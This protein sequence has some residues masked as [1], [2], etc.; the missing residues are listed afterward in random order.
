MTPTATLLALIVRVAVSGVVL[1]EGR[2]THHLDKLQCGEV[3]ARLRTTC[4]EQIQAGWECVEQSLQLINR[5]GITKDITL[6]SRL[7]PSWAVPGRTALDGY[8]AEWTC[9]QSQ[10]GRHYLDLLYTCGESGNGCASANP[11]GEWE[12]LVDETGRVVAGGRN[13]S[14]PG[15]LERLGLW[16]LLHGT[17]HVTGVGPNK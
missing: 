4:V 10:S 5:A 1:A 6:D 3:T 11:G 17:T 9:V 12:Q 2:L 16:K 15:S 8:V 13:G 7:V 14:A